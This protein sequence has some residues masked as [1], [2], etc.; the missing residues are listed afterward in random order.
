[1][2]SGDIKAKEHNS[3]DIHAKKIIIYAWDGTNYR[4]I[5]CDIDGILQVTT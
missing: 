3:A 1:M 4:R 2:D 5:V